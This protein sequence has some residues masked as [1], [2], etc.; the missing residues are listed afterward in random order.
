MECIVLYE[1][2]EHGVS[3]RWRVSAGLLRWQRLAIRKLSLSAQRAAAVRALRAREETARFPLFALRTPTH[4][5]PPHARTDFVRRV[6][7]RCTELA[8]NHLQ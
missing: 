2:Y 4:S 8:V 1:T 3:M 7:Q 5:R 6:R